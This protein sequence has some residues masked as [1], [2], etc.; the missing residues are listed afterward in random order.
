M[1]LPLITEPMRVKR[2]VFLSQSTELSSANEKQRKQS[3]LLTICFPLPMLLTIHFPVPMLLT[4]YLFSS[5]DAIDNLFSSSNALT[6]YFPL[7]MLLTEYLF[8][9][10]N[11]LTIYF[12]PSIHETHI[13]YL[14]LSISGS[15]T[16]SSWQKC[17]DHPT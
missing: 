4:E 17:R 14:S 12:P 13:L 8:S 15:L 2:K 11:A 9:S 16:P 5:P 10:S 7:P 3:M 1:F 6:I